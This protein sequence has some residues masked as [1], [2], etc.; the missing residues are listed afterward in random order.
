MRVTLHRADIRLV[1]LHG[2]FH[3]GKRACG[4][5]G[6]LD[7]PD[8]SGSARWVCVR[9]ASMNLVILP[10]ALRVIIPP[11]ISQYLN[12]TKNSS[13]AIAVG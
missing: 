8:R 6:D 13:L 7:R 3:R 2:S 12:I 4:Y 9:V 10:Q 5:L 11:L 1:D